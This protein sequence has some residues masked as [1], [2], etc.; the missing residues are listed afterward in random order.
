MIQAEKYIKPVQDV[1]ES[2]GGYIRT[3]CGGHVHV[4]MKPTI[5]LSAEDFNA[6]QIEYWNLNTNPT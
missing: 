2:F 5:D 4:G 6:E 3:N 1:V